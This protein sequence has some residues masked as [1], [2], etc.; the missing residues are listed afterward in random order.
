MN[1]TCIA[2]LTGLSLLC[3]G[4]VTHAQSD[5][6]AWLDETLTYQ[7]E[8]GAIVGELSGLFDSEGYY[9]DRIPPGL[10]FQNESF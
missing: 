10:L 6:L 3:S 9:I 4:A 7:S 8:N 2:I 5:P 1:R